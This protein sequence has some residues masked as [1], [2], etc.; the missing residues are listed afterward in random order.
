MKT[1]TYHIGCY[2]TR[3]RTSNH[4][5]I[6]LC[7]GRHGPIRSD[8]H[9]AVSP[10]FT[11]V[12]VDTDRYPYGRF[13][14]T[15][16]LIEIKMPFIVSVYDKSCKYRV[17]PTLSSC[18]KTEISSNILFPV[19]TTCKKTDYQIWKHSCWLHWGFKRLQMQPVSVELGT[20]RFNISKRI[21]ILNKS[22]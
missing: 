11:C 3:F 5:I 16:I 1:V 13:T 9:M 6:Y 20:F 22:R 14:D 7:I 12:S 15:A 21:R 10:L 17:K 4:T 19:H 18:E 2:V 8:I